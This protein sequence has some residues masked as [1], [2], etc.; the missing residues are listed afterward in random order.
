[1]DRMLFTAMSGAREIE[2]SLAVNT[3]NLANAS[4]VGFRADLEDAVSRP[5]YGPGHPDR[6]FSETR[7]HGTMNFE[8]GPRITTGRDLDV[9]VDG[10]GWLVVQAPD[11]SQAVTRNGNL[12]VDVSGMLVNSFDQ[13][14]MGESG[15]ITLPPFDKLEIAADGNVSI[16]P[17]GQPSSALAVLDRLL[18]VKPERADLVK[19]EDGLIRP[20]DG[21]V[22]LPDAAVQV[23]SGQLE[24][25][26]VNSVDAMVR[27]IELQRQFE[28]QVRLMRIAEDNDAASSRVMRLR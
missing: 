10:D 26:N 15:P 20:R 11:G 19:G 12:R 7:D 24:S 18:L 9:A 25:S 1:M 6:V 22:L 21:A 5:L 17:Q 4:T 28:S 3:H 23:S 27:M 16:V 13:P 2:R 14:V 8:A